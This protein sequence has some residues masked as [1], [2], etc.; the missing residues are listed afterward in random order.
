MALVSTSQFL[1]TILGL[2]IDNTVCVI[3]FMD[4]S[5]CMK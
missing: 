2:D 3:A 1:D 4:P 5:I